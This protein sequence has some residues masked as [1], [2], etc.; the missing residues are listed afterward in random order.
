[1]FGRELCNG[2]PVFITIT[3][4]YNHRIF[5]D[6]DGSQM[7]LV[8]IT[9]PPLKMNH[10]FDIMSSINIDITNKHFC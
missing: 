7:H 9:L 2:T 1:M 8:N 5:H 6:V 3:G 4:I 10:L